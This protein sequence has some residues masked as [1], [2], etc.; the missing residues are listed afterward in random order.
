MDLYYDP[1]PLIPGF[2]CVV[3]A[4]FLYPNIIGKD[5]S[6][7]HKTIGV[8]IITGIM[9]LSC[10]TFMA[11]YD[12][13]LLNLTLGGRLVQAIIYSITSMLLALLITQILEST[14]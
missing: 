8:T 12:V 14:S 2:M 4:I 5:K 11:I 10:Y 1:T 3:F 13:F 7:N 6:L 9:S